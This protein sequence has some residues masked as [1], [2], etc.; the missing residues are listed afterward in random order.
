M[1][2]LLTH[3]FFIIFF[4]FWS[5]IFNSV[6][7]ES[8]SGDGEWDLKRGM[9]ASAWS[10]LKKYI[11]RRYTVIMVDEVR[12]CVM[13]LSVYCF[14]WNFVLILRFFS[15][16]SLLSFFSDSS[17]AS[18]PRHPSSQ[19]MTSSKCH[20]CR[21]SCTNTASTRVMKCD[22]HCKNGAGKDIGRD[23]NAVYNIAHRF[24]AAW[25]SPDGKPDS[26]LRRPMPAV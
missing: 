10:S 25:L 5:I 4:S 23:E 11:I 2:S 21:Q 24:M 8:F 9:K 3:F 19:Y 14:A 16:V 7:F 1:K 15:Y 17:F 26:Y 13:L 18:H 22:S 6:P 20:S 12:G